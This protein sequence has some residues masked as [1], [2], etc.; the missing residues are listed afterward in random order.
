TATLPGLLGPGIAIFGVALHPTQPWLATTA[1]VHSNWGA[2]RIDL[3]EFTDEGLEH[4]G[5]TEL[6]DV[7]DLDCAYGDLGDCAITELV[8]HPD[9]TR[10]YVNEDSFDVVITFSVNTTTGA[11][12]FL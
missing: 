2:A 9:G 6:Y 11:L 3:F 7:T 4:L 5:T 12:A 1:M 10:L 8:F